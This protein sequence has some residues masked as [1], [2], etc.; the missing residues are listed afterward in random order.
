MRPLG[1]LFA[2]SLLHLYEGQGKDLLL[3]VLSPV[4]LEEEDEFRWDFRPNK[5]PNKKVMR[6]SYDHE[7][8]IFG[9]YKG[10]AV[11]SLQ[12]YSLHLRNMQQAD[13]GL[14]SA[15]FGEDEDE[16]VGEYSVTVQDPV[17]PVELTV[18]FASN[19]SD[20]CILTVTCCTR[21][22]DHINS[23][24]R[25][26]N[27]T[28]SLNG[29]EMS[30]VTS[31]GAS[32]KVYLVD[33]TITC[34]HSNEVSSSIKVME[35]VQQFCQ[36]DAVGNVVPNE[37]IIIVPAVTSAVIGAVALSLCFFIKWKIKS[38]KHTVD[39]VPQDINPVQGLSPT[40]THAV[41]SF[42]TRPVQ[43]AETQDT[44]PP[45]TVYA[46]VYRAAKDKVWT[47]TPTTNT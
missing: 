45:E 14:Y 2:I 10:R 12:N 26:V 3:D 18:E 24:L 47:P 17:S 40:A 7:T 44:V 37:A 4:V 8:K 32:L 39:D 41:V 33:G 22:S 20:S 1:L 34:S 25:C 27:S 42:H 13:S 6:V 19:S 30:K 15:F 28:C 21:V 46:Q 11:I 38:C 36:T 35:E 5:K 16:L 23:I 29:G 43:S 31:F 9:R